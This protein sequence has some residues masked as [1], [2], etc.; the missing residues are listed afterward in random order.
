MGTAPTVVTAT[1]SSIK[2]GILAEQPSLAVDFTGGQGCTQSSCALC[3]E[4]D[5]MSG[6]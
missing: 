4:M 6:A 1:A 3:I 2:K 5:S